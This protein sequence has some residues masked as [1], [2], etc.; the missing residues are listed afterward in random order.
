MYYPLIQDKVSNGLSYRTVKQ[1]N[2][3]IDHRLPGRPT[4]QCK[5]IVIR[6][7]SLDFYYRDMLACIQSLFGD[8]QYAQDLA[9]APE[10]HFTSNERK[11]RLYHEMYIGDWWWTNQVRLSKFLKTHT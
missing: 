7:E 3:F 8:P 1:F 6:Q 5:Q 10:R 2:D 4:F 9:F 11:S